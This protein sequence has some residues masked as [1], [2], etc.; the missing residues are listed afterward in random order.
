MSTATAYF[1]LGAHHRDVSTTSETAQTWVDRGLN[2]TYG[3]NHEEAILCFEH[4]LEEDPNCAIAHW[5][6]AY[7][8]GPN[9]NKLWEMFEPAEKVSA[10]DTAHQSIAA[11]L[12]IANSTATER[13][14][15]GALQHRY[16]EDAEIEDF[17]PYNDAFADAM[18]EVYNDNPA[19]LDVASVFA[20]AQDHTIVV[21]PRLYTW[22]A[23]R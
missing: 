9:Y 3:F 20:E 1:D 2:W 13:A 12:A 7:C 22:L 17:G 11:G 6:I 23:R 19:D 15:L 4:A 18:R 5:G 8:I 10:L 21:K 14:L 16:P